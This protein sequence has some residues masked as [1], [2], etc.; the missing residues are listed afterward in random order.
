MSKG[1]VLNLRFNQEQGCFTCCMDNGLRI[2][3]VNPLVEKAN[4][5]FGSLSQ[6]EMLHRTN[7]FAIVAGGSNAKFAKNSVL[8]YDDVAKKFIVELVFTTPVKAV[9][10]RRDKI[11]VAT[12]NQMNVFS[13]PNPVQRLFTQDTRPN[14]AGL[15]EVSPS[16]TAERH[17]IAFPG[18]KLGSVQFID[19][20]STEMSSSSSPVTINAHQ[21][22]LACLALNQTGTMIATASSKGTLIRVWD[23]MKK[24]LLV[25]LRRGSDP[26]TLY[27][28][29]FSRDSEFL[30]CS[31]DKG[32]IHIFA[33]KNTKLNRR[34]TFSSMGF[35]GNYVESQWALAN[36]TLPPECAC[37]CAFGSKN[38]VIAICLDGTFHKY[39]FN[40]DG[41]CNRESFDIY[42]DGCG[43]DDSF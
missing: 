16:T 33:L 41:N 15:C 6:C 29:N 10:L 9:R 32:T 37:I 27:C 25:E 7:I 34:S 19:L 23:T 18:H 38:T 13:F 11:I 35:L 30:C 36:F 26:A 24:L 1:Q 39:V 5:D 22:E 40:A 42:L 20:S 12:V 28:I 8:I 4:Y 17:L 2:Y 14:H 43:E 21:S 31:S 3:N